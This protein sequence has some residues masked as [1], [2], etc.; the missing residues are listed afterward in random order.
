MAQKQQHQQ[1]FDP[2]GIEQHV[3]GAKLDSGKLAVVKMVFSYFAKALRAVGWLSDTG[4]KK[5]SYGGWSAVADA[6]ARYTEACGR[7]LLDLAEGEEYVLMYHDKELGI[8]YYHHALV[9]VA[10]NALAALT[11]AKER[12]LVTEYTETDQWLED[13]Q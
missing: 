4:A 9:A 8:K 1:E 12:G 6:E 5:Y 10:W 11:K 7:H 3:P 2:N 13:G